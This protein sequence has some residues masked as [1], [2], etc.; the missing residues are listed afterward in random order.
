MKVLEKN[1]QNELQV[2]V[3][4]IKDEMFAADIHQVKEIRGVDKVTKVPEAPDVL[5]G[6]IHLRGQIYPIVNLSKR[7]RKDKYEITPQSRTII[8]DLKGFRFGVIV[9][10]VTE[11]IRVKKEDI[12]STPDILS[13]QNGYLEGVIKRDEQLIL[14]VN[15]EKILTDKEL[16]E[17]NKT[18]D[19]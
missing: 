11:V 18:K 16:N 3:F 10:E 12:Q 13:S 5:E 4:K 15:L 7:F 19:L 6:I 8:I 1:T 14:F 2:V 17:I 9:D